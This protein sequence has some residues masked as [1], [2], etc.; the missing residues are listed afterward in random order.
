MSYLLTQYLCT[1]S[2]FFIVSEYLIQLAARKTPE[3]N[4]SQAGGERDMIKFK[5]DLSLALKKARVK[6][7]RNDFIQYFKIIWSTRSSSNFFNLLRYTFCESQSDWGLH[8]H[9]S[10]C[11]RIEIISVISHSQHFRWR[12]FSSSVHLKFIKT[13]LLALKIKW[14]I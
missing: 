12:N 8:F 5:Y 11:T 3:T 2:F 4:S 6:N 1:V 7:N 13:V 14:R 9:R 10:V